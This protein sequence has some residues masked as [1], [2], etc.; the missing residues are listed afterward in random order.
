MSLFEDNFLHL[1]AEAF[2]RFANLIDDVGYELQA[3]VPV[4]EGVVNSMSCL[5]ERSE[6][7]ML[8]NPKTNLP[9]EINI[10]AID[11]NDG[12]RWVHPGFEEQRHK[13]LGRNTTT[14]CAELNPITGVWHDTES[15]DDIFDKVEKISQGLPFDNRVVIVLDFDENDLG[16]LKLMA[17]QS[18]M[19]F[20]R[21]VEKTLREELKRLD[22]KA[23]PKKK[24][25]S[26]N[27]PTTE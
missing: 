6:F 8:Y 21:F 9:Y 19:E 24:K 7:Q 20:D 14:V 1:H 16:I 13:D 12:Y 3:E 17:E 15:L 22:A 4:Y 2:N 25:K 10:R 27:P 18:G 5:N 11:S 26:K 23:F